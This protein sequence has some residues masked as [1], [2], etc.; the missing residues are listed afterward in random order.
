M[1]KNMDLWR[2]LEKRYGA[3]RAPGVYYGMEQKGEVYP[4]GSVNKS[5]AP[6]PPPR[7]RRRVRL[8]RRRQHA[9]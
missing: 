9:G 5:K 3:D 2:A 8:E 1:P 6:L 4:Q 7:R